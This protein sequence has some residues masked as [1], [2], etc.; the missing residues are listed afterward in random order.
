MSTSAVRRSPRLLEKEARLNGPQ[1]AYAAY[2]R[3]TPQQDHIKTTYLLKEMYTMRP[4]EDAGVD[5]HREHT[6]KYLDICEKA[7]YKNCKI[8]IITQLFYYLAGN[9]KKILEYERFRTVVVEKMLEIDDQLWNAGTRYSNDFY[10]S[11]WYLKHTIENITG[12]PHTIK[13]KG[14]TYY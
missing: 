10:G 6:K 3:L 5:R 9:G 8:R 2:I 14:Y 4:A 12:K 11:A 13:F 1:P 7:T